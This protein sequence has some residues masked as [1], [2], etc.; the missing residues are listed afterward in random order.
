MLQV[1]APTHTIDESKTPEPC[2]IA[3]LSTKP[4]ITTVPA[5]NPVSIAAWEETLKPASE[6]TGWSRRC[7]CS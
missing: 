3:E 4:A 1:P 2:C 6:G 5:R 7:S